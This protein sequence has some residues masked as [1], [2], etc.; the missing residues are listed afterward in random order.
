MR[1]ND[2]LKYFTATGLVVVVLS[3][4]FLIY[5]S[6]FTV[7]GGN[8]FIIVAFIIGAG[9]AFMIPKRIRSWWLYQKISWLLA[10]IIITTIFGIAFW[11]NVVPILGQK[12]EYL[13]TVDYLTNS[14]DILFYSFGLGFSYIF[15]MEIADIWEL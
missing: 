8:F 10:M 1:V 7:T 5:H 4:L 15:Y 13:C 12:T 9:I 14:K 3:S 6:V 2:I 11:M